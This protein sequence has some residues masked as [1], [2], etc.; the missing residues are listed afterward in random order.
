MK[1]LF[2]PVLCYLGNA[3]GLPQGGAPE[4]C[5]TCEGS[6]LTH[7]HW[8]RLEKLTRLNHSNL[9]QIFVNYVRKSFMTLG[10]CDTVIILLRPNKL[11]CFS[12]ARLSSLVYC[13]RGGKPG[14]YPRAEHL[15][16]RV[17]SNFTLKNTTR[18]EGLP[19]TNTLAYWTYSQITSIKSFI[20]MGPNENVIKT[21]RL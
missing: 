9:L 11:K 7:K 18:L 17:G 12:L 5:L 13:W 16:T 14:A 3:R 15:T 1:G 6:G 20:S 10:P 8:T 21:L 19:W 2:S 4:K